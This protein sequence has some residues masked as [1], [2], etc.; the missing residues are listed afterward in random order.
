M[1]NKRQNTAAVYCRLSRDDGGDAQSNSIAT[2]RM[3]LTKYAH[4]NGF[5]VFD[6][7][8]D[9]GISGT[10]FER[11]NFKRMIED[12]EADK[13]D[14]VIVKDLSR[15][16]RNNA[17]VSFYTEIFFVD[18]DVRFIAV[19]D[20]IDSAMG[21]NEIMP[22]KSVI[23][24]YYARDISKKV[25]SAK[26]VRAQKGEF[27]A[28]VAPIGYVKNPQ[29]RHHLLVE[30]DGAKIVKYIFELAVSG[31]GTEK[32]AN[33]LNDEGITTIRRHWTK[34]YPDR[35]FDY[36]PH[37]PPAWR[38]G[39]VRMIL[40]NRTYLGNVVN[41]KSTTKSFK[42]RKIV[43]N[44]KDTWVEVADMHEA[45]IDENTFNL[46][47]RVIGVKQREN[48][49]H[50][51]NIYAGLLKCSDCGTGLSYKV[52]K[53]KSGASESFVC[54]RY[55]SRKS[56]E[57]GRSCSGHYVASKVLEDT[58][59]GSVRR[60]AADAR[61][62]EDDL[63]VFA[64]SIVKGNSDATQR[65][66]K[67]ELDRL[68]RRK[69]ELD[70]I[71][72]R[73]YEDSVL[74]NISIERYKSMATKYEQELTQVTAKLDDISRKMNAESDRTD[75]AVRFL[76]AVRKYTD[77]KEVT[78][79]MLIELVEKI[80]IHNAIGRGKDRKQ[81]IDIHFRFEWTV[82]SSVHCSE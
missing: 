8:I 48:T 19:N 60:Y 42:N 20:G 26:R 59:L 14:T 63:V 68:S 12:I 39:S 34:I 37:L 10:T 72:E 67:S 57:T 41:G 64:E 25:R 80:V 18:H 53:H 29:N 1:T 66:T 50:Y 22:F 31:L 15:L 62:H 6:E 81:R 33:R 58:V 51:D 11:P 61:A 71:I 23:N 17:L 3:M 28:H 74:G 69:N 47:Q 82:D 4:D 7:Y 13:V 46:A 16:G 65:Q 24:E 75:N 5:V 56:A 54:T 52:T 44:P 38:S 45:I 27:S 73:M 43:K 30:E 21:D 32:I 70:T 35:T 9:D 55:R 78:R 49:A 79:P 2:Q 40:K 77:I 36:A 76:T